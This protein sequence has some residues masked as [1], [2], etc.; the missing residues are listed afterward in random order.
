MVERTEALQRA[1]AQ[2]LRTLQFSQDVADNMPGAMSYWD[3]DLVCRFANKAY[4]QTFGSTPDRL[5]ADLPN[6]YLYAAN[7]PSEGTIAKR[8]A[9]A[10]LVSYL[11]PPIAH[12]GLYRGLLDLKGSVERFRFIISPELAATIN[13]T[14]TGVEASGPSVFKDEIANAT[15]ILNAILY[16]VALISLIV[17]GI[18]TNG[19]VASTVRDA[20]VREFD[21]VVL[22][23]GCAAFSRQVHEVSIEALRPVAP[24][25]SWPRSTPRA[26]RCS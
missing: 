2:Q 7:N 5:I 20:H 8:R 10:T 26:M 21:C 11:T 4:A 16:G 3:A 25:S 23:D 9:A 13:Q 22:S 18:V 19:G 12:A 14:V 15:R 6:V 24:F 1:T 17:G